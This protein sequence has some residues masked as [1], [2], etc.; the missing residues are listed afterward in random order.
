MRWLSVCVTLPCFRPTHRWSWC[1]SCC[2]CGSVYIPIDHARDT[3]LRFPPAPQIIMVLYL[4]LVWPYTAWQLQGLE[5]TCHALE[6]GLFAA[7]LAVNT[8]W[9]NAYVTLAMVVMFLATL[10][11]LL[12]FELYRLWLVVQAGWQAVREWWAERK[13]KAERMAAEARERRDGSGD[14]E[15][16]GA[17]RME[18]VGEEGEAVAVEVGSGDG[19]RT[20]ARPGDR[21]V[22]GR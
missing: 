18:R 22:D 14:E 4:L 15:G 13:A 1:C 19:E 17:G 11:L 6:L 20:G 12:V 8:Q 5:L 9:A 21:E 3:I 16:A 2:W 10:V 7:A